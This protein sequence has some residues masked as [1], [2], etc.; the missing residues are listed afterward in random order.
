M[1]ANHARHQDPVSRHGIA[2]GERAARG[3]RADSRSCDEHAVGRSAVNDLRIGG[4]Q[5]HAC[6]VAGLTHR[7]HDPRQV[8]DGNPFLQDE[9]GGQKLGDRPA[10]GQIVDRPVDGQ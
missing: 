5:Q 10:D 1:V 9:C 4:Y 8:A 6:F 3:D 2:N 7:S